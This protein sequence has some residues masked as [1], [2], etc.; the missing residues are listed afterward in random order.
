MCRKSVL[1]TVALLVLVLASGCT[2]SFNRDG[3]Q[4]RF[5]WNPDPVAESK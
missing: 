4:L 2:T 3:L 5:G 1:L